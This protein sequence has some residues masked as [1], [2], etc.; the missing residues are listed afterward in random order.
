MPHWPRC[1]PTS[2][3]A[4]ACIIDGVRRAPRRLPDPGVADRYRSA[5]R[6][7]RLGIVRGC[8]ARHDR[9]RNTPIRPGARA[10]PVSA[11]IICAASPTSWKRASTTSRPRSVWKSA[12]TAWKPW[13]KR[14]KRWIS[15]AST[16][17]TSKM[18]RA[19]ISR[20]P[21]D[22][23]PG[24]VSTNRSILRPYGVWAVIAPFNF[25]LALMG[26]PVAAALVTGNVVIAKGSSHTPWAGRLLADCIRDAGLPAGVFQCLN[27]SSAEVGRALIGASGHRRHHLHRLGGCRQA[28]ADTHCV[29]GAY[30]KPCIA[31]MGGKN[32]CIVTEH[33]DLDA[34]ASGI[35]RS[36]F[37]LSGQK[38]SALSRLYVHEQVA[39]ALIA[40]LDEKT[41]ALAIGDPTERV[42]WLGPV[43]KAVPMPI[44]NGYVRELCAGGAV[45]HA[46]GRVLTDGDMARGY[47]VTPV[48]AEAPL[49]SP[50]WRQEMFLP[51]LM[52]HR[53][54]TKQQAMASGQR[55][56]CR[57]DRRFLRQLLPKSPGST[58]TSKPASPTPTARRAPPPA[59]GRAISRS[60]AGKA[61]GRPAR[62]SP[63][64]IICRSICA[65]SHA[66]WSADGA[67]SVAA[68][69]HRRIRP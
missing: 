62:P 43:N 63:R 45:M 16:P 58:S 41:A 5:A 26:G 51:I 65:S 3:N 7:I 54:A 2:A 15:S 21:N 23:L 39:D 10:R 14:R 30:P 36:A 20:L 24:I 35:V 33:A 29:T 22:P 61:P 52:L 6:R 11:P 4:M 49:S 28:I 32:A 59:R 46:G 55:Q 64:F 31:E 17:M 44:T 34:A 40:K 68:R 50:L 56:R 12:R 1:A 57:P 60:A 9:R 19:S 67:F 53:V 37:G 18:P 42:N 27:G 48:I 13:A 38:C 66:R 69:S 8:R 47:F 25:P